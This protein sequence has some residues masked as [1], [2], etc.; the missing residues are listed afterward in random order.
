[1]SKPLLPKT[2]AKAESES[3]QALRGIQWDLDSPDPVRLYQ[4]MSS[5]SSAQGNWILLPKALDLLRHR[6]K[7]VQ[8]AA[9]T[10]AA[11][12]V[13]G[14]YVVDMFRSMSVLNPVDR[15]QTL[16]SIQERFATSR[17]PNTAS[18]QRLWIEELENLGREHQPSVF[19]LMRHLGSPGKR[20]VTKQ[21]KEGIKTMSLGAVP[22]LAVFSDKDRNRLIKIMSERAAQQKRELLP[23][24]CGIVD[25][26][27]V[28]HLGVFLKGS[29]WQERVEIAGALATNGVSVASGLLM[30]LVGDSNWQ[31]KQALLENLSIESSKFTSLL[32]M[33]SFLVTET[34]SRVRGLAERTLLLLGERKCKESS[35]S[36]QRKRLEKQFRPQLLKAANANKDLDLRWLGVEARTPDPMSEILEK[37]SDDKFAQQADEATA[38]PQGVSLLDLAQPRPV[39]DAK[40]E[41]DDRSTLLTALLDARKTKA[42]TPKT[43]TVSPGDSPSKRF[44]TMLQSLAGKKGQGV[45][46]DKLME[47]AS[48]YSLSHEELFMTMAELEKQGII[49]RSDKG[50]VSY[51]GFDM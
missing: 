27:S 25:T 8:H 15:E 29:T 41:G 11:K 44:I 49:Y 6:E 13:Y 28:K 4:A 16:Q 12:S 20:W 23:Y 9:F 36:D 1:M 38:E 5:L 31:V 10:L 34:H 37:V 18:E 39:D 30:Q 24:I 45:S 22:A 19:L 46:M 42:G 35:I 21:I 26:S 48:E 14:S 32:R 51:A 3:V 33:L 47:S 2:I 50:L 43:P 17:A 40:A 7:N